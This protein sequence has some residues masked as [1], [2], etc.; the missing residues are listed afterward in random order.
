MQYLGIASLLIVLATAARWFQRA[1]RVNIPHDATQFQ[2]L[3]G[4]GLVLAVISLFLDARSAAAPWGAGLA[5]LFLYLSSTGAQRVGG[6]MIEVGSSLPIFTALD[7]SGA[8]FD[9]ASLKG[10]RVLLKF[11][12]GHW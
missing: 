5:V 9:A 12:R 6:E 1:W 3:W 4:I 11:F 8:T 7:D 10:S 2:L